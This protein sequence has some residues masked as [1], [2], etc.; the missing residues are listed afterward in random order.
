[1]W[2][3]PHPQ[4]DADREYL[5]QYIFPLFKEKHLTHG[6]PG[7]DNFQFP[8]A[9]DPNYSP[10]LNSFYCFMSGLFFIG[11]AMF[12][13]GLRLWVRSRGTFGTDDW[14]TLAAFLCYCAFNVVNVVAVFDSGLG[15]HLYDN[16]M[17]DIYSFLV[18]E[19]LHVIL[20]FATLHLLRC[21]I[22]H[23]FLR[24]SHLQSPTQR[25][26][27]YAVNTASYL[28]LVTCVMFEVFDCGLP[29]AQ[30][31]FRLQ[32]QFDGTCI[33]SRNMVLYGLLI[34]GHIILDALTIFPPM[35]VL[36]RLPLARAKKFNLIFL[37]VLGVFTMVFSAIRLYVFYQIMIDSFDLTWN[38]T[39]VAFWGILESSLAAVI[40]S[41]PALN[42]FLKRHVRRV[43]HNSI[44]SSRENSNGSK[45]KSKSA[46]QGISIFERHHFF[47]GAGKFLSF[48]A[49]GTNRGPLSVSARGTTAVPDDT[50]YLELG[51]VK[52]ERQVTTIEER[53]ASDATTLG[54]HQRSAMDSDPDI[55][56]GFYISEN[57]SS[58]E[59][60]D[61]NGETLRVRDVQRPP[62]AAL[63]RRPSSPTI[64]GVLN[65]SAVLNHH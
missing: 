2:G 1:M 60:D 33:G 23:L 5:Q 31:T 43:Y 41:L 10:P 46:G 53:K 14:V 58:E 64:S 54:G 16:S 20:L 21:S 18:L 25:R 19:Y 61:F 49:G 13:V 35:F 47:K 15:F 50:A 51:D 40:V 48:S 59:Q 22:I 56:R 17:K 36:A 7:G 45:S 27:L 37:L 9:V 6:L 42:Q 4:T 28:Y 12:V 38:A 34:A 55:I 65:S 11:I 8:L 32:S 63:G 24:L 26:Y 44:G 39:G 62:R 29:I 52:S 30:K 3:P 57:S